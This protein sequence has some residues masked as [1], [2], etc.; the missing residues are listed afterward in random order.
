MGVI[1]PIIVAVG[2]QQEIR[3]R[4]P[5]RSLR[6]EAHLGLQRTAALLEHAFE[7]ALKPHGITATQYNALRILR[8]A[9]AGGLCRNE[10]RERLVRQV[11][12]VTRLLDRLEDLQL[13][14]RTRG[15]DDRRFVS[16][17]ITKRGLELLDDLDDRIE[18]IHQEQL[19]HLSREQLRT[20]ID[21][22]A[23]VRNRE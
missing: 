7:N 12:D 4:K 6:Q 22:L 9:G 16:A 20:L 13:V 8:G 18:E 23:A 1:T 17:T 19:G 2:R 15:G 3:Q 5:F 21:L 14:S 10:I 11:P